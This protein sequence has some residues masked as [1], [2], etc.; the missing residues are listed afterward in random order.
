MKKDHSDWFHSSELYRHCIRGCPDHDEIFLLEVVIAET[1]KPPQPHPAFYPTALKILLPDSLLVE[2]Q[3]LTLQNVS[4]HT[5]ALAG[6]RGDDG[7]QTTGLE[8][9]LESGLDLAAGGEA[10]SLLLLH[11]VALLLTLGGLSSLLLTSPAE[12]LAVVG[13]VPLSEG[14]GVD[15]DNGGLGEGVGADQLVV[16][17]VVGD[18][19]HADLTGDTLRSPGEVARVETQGTVLL[20]TTAGADEVDSLGANTGV[21]WLTTLLESPVCR[22]NRNRKKPPSFQKCHTQLGSLCL[23]FSIPLLAVEG[24]LRTGSR[25]LVTGVA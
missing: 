18:N 14:G 24:S 19:D 15:L 3:L 12:G 7:V 21:G 17:R 20:V 25:A 23:N 5:A 9:S 11:G 13:L 1:P 8:L 10:G 2:R 6:A 16:R 4:V 22:R